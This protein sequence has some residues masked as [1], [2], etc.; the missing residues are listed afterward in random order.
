[1]V[2]YEQITT[3]TYVLSDEANSIAKD[4]SHEYR[5]WQALPESGEAMSSA[6]LQVSVSFSH[7]GI[8]K[9]TILR[10]LHDWSRMK[11]C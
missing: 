5:V 7:N 1:M 3:T 2:E 11:E 8:P 9:Y 4:G 6:D 10:A